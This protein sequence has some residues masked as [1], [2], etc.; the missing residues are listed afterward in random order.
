MREYF[1]EAVVL[2][3]RTQGEYDKIADLYARDLG[4]IEVR[5]VSGRRVI[6]KL[7]PH[8]DVGHKVST[9][10]VYKNQFT[11]ADVLREDDFLK[12]GSL[13]LKTRI[14]GLFFL[15]RTTVPMM[16]PDFNLWH[17]LLEN[18][19]SGS[20]DYGIF[21]K[22]LGYD[23]THAKCDQCGSGDI[24]GF[25]TTNQVFACEPCLKVL[26]GKEVILVGR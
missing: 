25:F 18:L 7:S 6:S 13:I 19:E 8:F 9:R 15:L 24:K 16:V 21:L 4:R 5:V 12:N 3:V 17:R 1:T 10:L 14:L 11:V 26:P 23:I 2:D 20:V 22:I